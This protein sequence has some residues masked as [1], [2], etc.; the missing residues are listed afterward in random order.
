MSRDYN[1]F[2]IKKTPCGSGNINEYR[3]KQIARNVFEE[4]LTMPDN[5]LGEDICEDDVDGADNRYTYTEDEYCSND[6]H[7]KYQ[8]YINDLNDVNDNLNALKDVMS[9]TRKTISEIMKLPVFEA[10]SEIGQRTE[11]KFSFDE[12][13]TIMSDTI[14]GEIINIQKKQHSK[15]VGGYL[16]LTISDDRKELLFKRELYFQK[17]GQWVENTGEG[18]LRLSKFDWEKSKDAM[19]AILKKQKCGE[20]YKLSVDP[21]DNNN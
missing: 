14:D 20:I 15:Y 17:D 3:A 19:N 21:P 4:D 8:G 13:L 16:F 11:K 2:Y 18:R 7:T 1:D 12:Y 10:F 6:A 5:D 9:K